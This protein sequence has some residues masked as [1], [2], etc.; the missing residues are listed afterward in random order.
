M[1]YIIVR[2][3]SMWSVHKQ[4]EIDDIQWLVSNCLHDEWTHNHNYAKNKAYNDGKDLQDA[5]D[6]I[7]LWKKHDEVETI[8]WLEE[9]P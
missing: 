4:A 9:L 5:L 7:K 6:E 8:Y 1:K 2:C 3:R